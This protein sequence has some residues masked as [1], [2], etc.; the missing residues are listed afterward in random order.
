MSTLAHTWTPLLNSNPAPLCRSDVWPLGLGRENCHAENSQAL[1]LG[2][3][4][5]SQLL[6]ELSSIEPLKKQR[7]YVWGSS[8][9][10]QTRCP[11]KT[12]WVPSYRLYESESNLL[13]HFFSFQIYL[14]LRTINFWL[15]F[16]LFLGPL[17]RQ[18]QLDDFRA[19]TGQ[20]TKA[21]SAESRQMIL[22]Y[23]SKFEEKMCFFRFQTL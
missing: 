8:Y 14:L 23:T 10:R 15:L 5:F 4:S 13:P 7:G 22:I 18:T 17:G 9:P 12:A 11:S 6:W 3:G 19:D 1:E 2:I 20:E 16:F 21:L